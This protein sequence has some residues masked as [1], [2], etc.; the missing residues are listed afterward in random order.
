MNTEE[1]INIILENQKQ[2]MKEIGFVEELLKSILVN[3]TLDSVEGLV[4]MEKKKLDDLSPK[5]KSYEHK[6]EEVQSE[7][8][9]EK[10]KLLEILEESL[11]S[12]IG[13]NTI[14]NSGKECFDDNH[15]PV[16]VK[17]T[18]NLK[19]VDYSNGM[20]KVSHYPSRTFFW[21]PIENL[22]G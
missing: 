16:Y 3:N 11:R 7:I 14:I 2:L 21:T 9:D 19:I 20:Y 22:I 5:Q 8:L 12:K 1:K 17:H 10:L 15:N 6:Q 13:N 18:Y 4:N